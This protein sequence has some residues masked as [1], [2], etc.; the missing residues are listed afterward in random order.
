MVMLRVH[1]V[2]R[3]TLDGMTFVGLQVNGGSYVGM[4][5]ASARIM[6]EQLVITAGKAEAMEPPYVPAVPDWGDPET[7]GPETEG[8]VQPFAN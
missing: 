4:S 6:A 5:P 8:D 1:Q 2:S 7:L 3:I